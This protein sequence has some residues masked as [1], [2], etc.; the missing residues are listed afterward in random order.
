MPDIE[1]DDLPRSAVVGVAFTVQVTNLD[2]NTSADWVLV[3]LPNT[4]LQPSSGTSL[5]AGISVLVTVTPTSTG[6]LQLDLSNTT[7][8]GGKVMGS[9]ATLAVYP[10]ELKSYV[11]L[12][13]D[14]KTLSF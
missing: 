2:Q 11:E 8:G 13:E 9:P 3:T 6:H 12:V 4:Q 1:L 7:T 14:L 5:P 10:P